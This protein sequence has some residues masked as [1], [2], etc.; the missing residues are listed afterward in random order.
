MN[1]ADEQ[2]R[3]IEILIVEDNAAEVEL[4]RECLEGAPAAVRLQVAADGDKVMSLLRRH[5]ENAGA[6]R[7]DLILLDLHLP[8]QDGHQVL[9]EIKS[10][11]EL[12][13]IPVVIL[14][15]SRNEDDVMKCYRAQANSYIVKAVEFSRF[16]DHLRALVGFWSA[17]AILPNRQ[18]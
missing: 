9:A 17:I 7:P 14:S 15:S 10:D 11:R 12:S 4:L 2:G 16:R 5:G 6:A 18:P 13:H 8:R 3:P 1:T